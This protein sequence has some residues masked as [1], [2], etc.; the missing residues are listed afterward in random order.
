MEVNQELPQLESGLDE[1]VHLLA[2]RGRVLG[3]H[4]GVH[5]FT[6]GQRRGLK[7][8]AGEPLY[9]IA[10][11]PA[12]QRVVVDD[13]TAPVAPSINTV[14]G[15]CSATVTTAPTATDNCVGT[16]TGT[17]TDA[18]TYSTQ[19]VH[20]ITWKFNDGN[21]N[22]STATQLVVVDDVTAPVKPTIAT[23]TGECSVTVTAPTTTDNCKGTVT[24]T[25]S[26]SLSYNTQGS[27]TITWTFNDGNGNASTAAQLEV[28]KLKDNFY[29]ITSSSP[30]P[31]ET[32]SGGNVSVFITDT[33]VTLV[34]TKLANWG[35]ALLDKALRSLPGMEREALILSA[36]GQFDNSEIAEI[37][38]TPEHQVED[39]LA[40]ALTKVE[41]EYAATGREPMRQGSGQANNA[42]AAELIQTTGIRERRWI[43]EVETLLGLAS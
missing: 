32:F 39:K 41:T 9:V 21:G 20:V 12:T 23:A 5:H 40:V 19:G 28:V 35:Q 30:T 18:L 2:P 16:V 10:T 43:G 6:V 4:D 33:G 34:D 42:P 3:E 13:V 36:R 15:E 8:R 27:Y 38:A 22:T 29:V 25:T 31:R 1:S 24:G 11:E 17:T 37:M 7:S 26:D 14:T